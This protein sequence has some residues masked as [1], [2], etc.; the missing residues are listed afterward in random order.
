MY[1]IDIKM[2]NLSIKIIF[3]RTLLE[4]IFI[5]SP[6]RPNIFIVMVFRKLQSYKIAATNLV[7]HIKT[8]LR[9]VFKDFI[10]WIKVGSHFHYMKLNIRKPYFREIGQINLHTL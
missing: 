4:V 10:V 2:F 5:F 3:F 6:V 8:I 1:S 7:K 9:C